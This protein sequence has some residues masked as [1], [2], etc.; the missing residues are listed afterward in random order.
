MVY[1]VP[2]TRAFL[3]TGRPVARKVCIFR[4]CAC[5]RVPSRVGSEAAPPPFCILPRLAWSDFS[6]LQF[7]FTR[8][9]P[10]PWI[11]YFAGFSAM[12]DLENH[13]REPLKYWGSFYILMSL[14]SSE[15]YPKW[16]SIF[17]N[18]FHA[19]CRLCSVQYLRGY[20][21]LP[22]GL[23]VSYRSSGGASLWGLSIV[24]CSPW[25]SG[26]LR[27]SWRECF[28][29]LS[30]YREVFFQPSLLVVYWQRRFQLSRFPSLWRDYECS[31]LS[32]F[33]VRR[34]G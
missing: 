27:R 33:S 16:S 18:C 8:C 31:R 1:P 2:Y 5:Q 24:P 14:T 12:S 4:S 6:L 26:D 21:I 11:F 13:S 3:I 20:P 28:A 19:S 10:P 25:F 29:I 15:D 23:R 9:I 34:R 7:I 22:P 17:L 32:S 30:V